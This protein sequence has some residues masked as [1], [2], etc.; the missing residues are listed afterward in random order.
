MAS[1]FT[2]HSF[3]CIQCGRRGI[4]LAR[5]NSHNYGKH[6]RKRLWCPYC[7]CEVNHIECRNDDEVAEFTAAFEAGE[8]KDELAASL[9]YIEKDK[10]LLWS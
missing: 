4:D 8:Y 9:E 7:K 6:H 5:K 1:S 10:Q 2:T 3:Y